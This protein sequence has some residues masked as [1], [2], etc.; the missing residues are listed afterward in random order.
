MCNSCEYIAPATYKF[1]LNE[2]VPYTFKFS[3]IVAVFLTNKSPPIDALVFKVNPVFGW[4]DALYEP[5]DIFAALKASTAVLTFVTL[6][7]SP[8]KEPL[9]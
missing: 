7:P 8:K 3:E 6:V 4:K 9:N 2:P 1:P 5:V